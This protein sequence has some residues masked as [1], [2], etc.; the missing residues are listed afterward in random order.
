MDVF[1]MNAKVKYE[2]P[3]KSKNDLLQQQGQTAPNDLSKQI[4]AADSSKIK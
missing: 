4:N 1:R 3:S 2:T